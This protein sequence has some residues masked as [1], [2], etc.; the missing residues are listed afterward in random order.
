MPEKEIPPATRVDIYLLNDF[1]RMA[2]HSL[3]KHRDRETSFS[4]R[5]LKKCGLAK[6]S[7]RLF[8]RI[9]RLPKSWIFEK[10]IGAGKAC[11]SRGFLEVR[12]HRDSWGQKFPMFFVFESPNP[13]G[14]SDI[15]MELVCLS[16]GCLEKCY[17]R[18]ASISGGKA[19][20]DAS[21]RGNDALVGFATPPVGVN[22]YVASGFSGIDVMKIA[23]NAIPFII[24]F[25]IALLI[26]TFVPFL[27]LAFIS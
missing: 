5:R 2:R 11:K 3:E 24:T 8:L 18:S 1:P 6:A 25:F 27:S 16:R 20:P 12:F 23:K 17:N 26:I 15:G 9:P 21:R 13:Q 19:D 4:P 7:E 14:R 22:L 10:G